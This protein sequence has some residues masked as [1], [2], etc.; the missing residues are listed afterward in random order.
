MS[1]RHGG[2]IY[3]TKVNIDFSVNINPLGMPYM[4]RDAAIRG[5]EL[6]STYPDWSQEALRTAVAEHFDIRSDSLIFGNGATDLIYRL[7]RVLE[8]KETVVMAPS[9]AEYKR[10]AEMAGSRVT[11]II[12]PEKDDFNLTET[13]L[14]ELLRRIDTLAAGSVLFLCNPNNPDGGVLKK[15]VTSRILSVCERQGVW[16]VMDECFLPFIA[17]DGELSLLDKVRDGG[18]QHLIVLR[19]FTKIY[20]MP[21]LRLGYIASANVS[22]LDSVRNSMTPWEINIPAEMAG[23]SAI[24]DKRFIEDTRRIVISERDFLG[25][26]LEKLSFVERVYNP[27]SQANFIL[28]KVRK[29]TPDLKKEL[30]KSGILIRSCSDYTGLDDSFYRMCVRLR[31]DN[32]KFIA[33][34]SKMNK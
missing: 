18:Y 12:L 33:E 4:A 15:E 5:V 31:G 16:L 24:K 9:F 30:L 8:A 26:E 1:Y 27:D 13:G 20:G 10:A 6:S 17:S 22:F 14:K 29:G 11:E 34:L 21:G 23:I 32:E 19:A 3:R 7:M 28:F 25:S 2:D